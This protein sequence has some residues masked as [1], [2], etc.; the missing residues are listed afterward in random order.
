MY[1]T[2][3]I[4]YANDVPHIG[5]AYT[6]IAAD[7]VARYHRLGGRR[8]FLLTGTD[9]HG[10]NIERIA[11]RRGLSPRQHVDEIA[12][13]FQALW[14]RLDIQYDR[15]IRTT[16]PDHIRTALDLWRRLQG[17]GDLYRGTY[18]GDSCTRCE[19]Y[20]APEELVEGRCPIH[21]LPCEHLR[22]EN[23]FFRL[24]RYEPA[25]QQLVAETDFVQPVPRRNEVLG[26]LSQGLKDF[27]VSRRHVRWGIPVPE[28]PD[29]VLY[30]W[31]DALA[32]YLSGGE[33]PA[34]T[35]LVGK[36]I[37][38]FHCLYWPALLLSAG[39]PLPRRVYAHGWLTRD[40]QKIS[41][42]TGNTIDPGSL[43]DQFGSDAVRYYFLRAVPFGKDGD[44]TH[45]AFVAS[46]N[47]DLANGF[48][49]LVQRV[50]T[51]AARHPDAGEARAAA[52]PAESSVREAAVAVRARV[53]TA[54]EALALNEAAI[55]VG[56]FAR[57]VDRYLHE[58]QPWQLREPAQLA[59]VLDHAVEAARLAAWHYAPFIPRA[60]AAAHCRLVGSPP[61]P[62]RDS[63]TARP[64]GS[65]RLGEPLFARLGASQGGR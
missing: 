59:T 6:T 60:A 14:S 62:G 9:E 35:H 43:A 45:A 10:I 27:S 63:F 58:T 3:P 48:G 51:L 4:Y 50:T 40:G 34:D 42:T 28:T 56:E 25:L 7:A 11:A 38:R 26:L 16:E 2:T 8:V 21:D 23:W 54:F 36:E 33:W 12:G 37:V 20:Y 5:H 1:L 29:E 46:Y 61:L 44:F 49:N 39:L 15:F 22:E 31:V 32:N 41:K 17:S 19:A 64:R 57:A 52:G 30:V 24:S 53:G 18:E 13:A 65:V 55:A 47:A